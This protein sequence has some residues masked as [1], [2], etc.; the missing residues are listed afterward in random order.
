MHQNNVAILMLSIACSM[1]SAAQVYGGDR[2]GWSAQTNE[3]GLRA[4]C[5]AAGIRYKT[6]VSFFNSAKTQSEKQKWREQLDRT[7]QEVN[8]YCQM[9]GGQSSGGK[10]SN[11]KNSAAQ[12]PTAP[13][14]NLAALIGSDDYP[15]AAIAAGQSGTTRFRLSISPNGGVTACNVT[16]SS[17]SPLL[18][19]TT[20]NLLQAR[21]RLTPAKDS[22]GNAI[23]GTYNGM[24]RWVL[25]PAPPPPPRPLP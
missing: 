14:G 1:P 17:G 10:P 9:T 11:Q 23:S 2:Q 24:I 3:N 8:E 15:A 6:Y 12:D 20:C 16:G 7:N 22:T 4:A 13:G 21:A 5:K 18:D 19:S 25:P